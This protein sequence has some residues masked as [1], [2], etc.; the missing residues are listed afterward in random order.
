MKG[1]KTCWKCSHF[2]KNVH[3][4][5]LLGGVSQDLP[6]GLMADIW[7]WL[8][9]FS[10]RWV[11]EHDGHLKWSEHLNL[12]DYQWTLL[13]DVTTT[14]VLNLRN[15]IEMNCLNPIPRLDDVEDLITE[16]RI[17]RARTVGVCT[18]TTEQVMSWGLRLVTPSS[19]TH[20]QGSQL[21]LLQIKK[22][23]WNYKV[24]ICS[25]I[26]IS[27]QKFY[28]KFHSPPVVY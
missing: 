10:E 23:V 17:W 25:I 3:N 9:Q 27:Q 4:S 11:T 21:E 16:N 5:K 18:F 12:Q 19:W 6:I 28:S 26:L 15:C 24:I 2:D 1:A 14:S 20:S 13:K 8:Q 22:S 7:D